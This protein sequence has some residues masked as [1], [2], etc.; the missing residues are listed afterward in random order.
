MLYKEVNDK[1]SQIKLIKSTHEAYRID[2]TKLVFKL[3]DIIHKLKSYNATLESRIRGECFDNNLRPIS[4]DPLIQSISELQA[5]K[6]ALIEQLMTTKMELENVKKESSL[7]MDSF[8]LPKDGKRLSLDLQSGSFSAL[9]TP[10][11]SPVA[12]RPPTPPEVF[13]HVVLY[14]VNINFRQ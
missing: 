11:T 2:Q 1:K 13:Q 12:V 9:S 6:M 5:D 14:N 4:I 10:L 8:Y 3:Q 7:N